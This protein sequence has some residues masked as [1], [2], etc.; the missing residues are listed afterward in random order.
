MRGRAA[1][2]WALVAAAACSSSP[3]PRAT[4]V[5]REQRVLVPGD[6][7]RGRWFAT[8]YS[9]QR[10]LAS[11]DA[12][13]LDVLGPLQ[14]MLC[15]SSDASLS[16]I[17]AAVQARL[18]ADHIERVPTRLRRTVD[19]EQAI[20]RWIDATATTGGDLVERE[21]LIALEETLLVEQVTP[22]GTQ[23]LTLPATEVQVPAPRC[24]PGAPEG[25]QGAPGAA[26]ITQVAVVLRRAA[27]QELMFQR[28]VRLARELEAQRESLATGAPAA[29]AGE[30][31][32]AERVLVGIAAR[33][34]M[35]LHE[36]ARTEQWALVLL[37]PEGQDP[38]E[39]VADVQ[40][41][42]NELEFRDEPADAGARPDGA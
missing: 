26:V 8:L 24:D 15:L 29:V 1:L 37:T 13:R 41:E 4:R 5:D 32:A 10:Q 35:H 17:S 21:A 14:T 7:P 20:A 3:P 16:R 28:T 11:A 6:N 30:F 9:L 19:S 36:S 42:D 33:A 23:R 27:A 12:R 39:P 18:A 40:P 25:S 22:A 31:G 34:T 38:P 2:A